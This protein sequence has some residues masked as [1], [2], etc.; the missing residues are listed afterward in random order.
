M[1]TLDL[2]QYKHVTSFT[3]KD[4]SYRAKKIDNFRK[5]GWLV[6]REH[7]HPDGGVTVTLVKN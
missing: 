2:S 3:G 4:R 7:V 6:K 5:Q 1:T